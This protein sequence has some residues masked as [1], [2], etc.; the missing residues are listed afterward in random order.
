M[1]W[2][3]LRA[4]ITL[5]VLFLHRDQWEQQA[6]TVR[7]QS[8]V[9]DGFNVYESRDIADTAAW[10]IHMS[11]AIEEAYSRVCLL[12]HLTS[13][14]AERFPGILFPCRS[15][16]LDKAHYLVLFDQGLQKR[17]FEYIPIDQL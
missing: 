3:R 15:I 10:L 6:W 13:F 2:T 12:N 5:S 4:R 11:K 8:Q 16:F 1:L 17:A 14:F 9:S 7:A